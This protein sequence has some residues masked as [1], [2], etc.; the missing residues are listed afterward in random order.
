MRTDIVL[1]VTGPDRVGIVEE[2]TGI[3]LELDGNVEASRM[4]RLGGE[5]AILSLVSMPR[6]HVSDIDSAFGNLAAR[7]Y[8]VNHEP[9]LRSTAPSHEGWRAYR[10]EVSG[11]DHEGIIHEIAAGLARRG[12][13]IESAETAT[14]A[15]PL[16]GTTLFSMAAMVLAPPMLSD[17]EWRADLAEAARRTNVDVVVSA[18]R[19]E[20][21]D[22]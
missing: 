9:A 14:S 10:V 22:A 8:R 16:S 4:A 3:L 6:E 21:P 12:I 15:A 11:A 1:T 2:V 17:D 13:T 7:G 20:T 19:R 18:T 5:F